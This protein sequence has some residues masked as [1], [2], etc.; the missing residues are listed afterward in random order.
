MGSR[1]RVLV[2]EIISPISQSHLRVLPVIVGSE[3][4]RAIAGPAHGL[5]LHD[6]LVLIVV[7]GWIGEALINAH[8]I[9]GHHV[10]VVVG[11]QLWIEHRETAAPIHL[12]LLRYGRWGMSRWWYGYVTVVGTGT[13]LVI[14]VFVVVTRIRGEPIIVE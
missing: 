4:P 9:S 6:F 8:G 12:R 11:Q 5:W 7:P 2:S 1:R 3:G 13:H 14:K 10:L